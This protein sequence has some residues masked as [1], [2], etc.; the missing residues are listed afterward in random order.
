VR[1]LRTVALAF[2]PSD[3]VMLAVQAG[4]VAAPRADPPGLSWL[5]RLGGRW[6]SLVPLGSIVVVIFAIRGASE[7]ATG[8]TYLALV[9]V[10]ILAALALGWGMRGARPVAALAA[11]ILFAVAWIWRT[12]LSG[13]GA[14]LILS[15]LSC[16]TLGILLSALTPPSWLKVGIVLMAIGDTYLVATDLLQA[17]NNT[18]TLAHPVAGLPQL[19]S[20]LFGNIQMG[21][22]DLFIAAVLGA[23]LANQIH[24]QRQAAAL[25]LLFAAAFDLLFFALSELPATVP[26]A[27]ALIASELW[28]RHTSN[29]KTPTTKTPTEPAER[30]SPARGAPRSE[31][32]PGMGSAPIV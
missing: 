30:P 23:V 32:A 6:W 2:V 8:L 29:T 18:L 3:A 15:A 11:P 9:A 31:A 20:E 19:Q 10:P 1:N 14:A 16:V 22:G 25:T 4:I 17:P 13:E 5:R 26:V 28:H 24:R 7:T 21:Y 12:S 27:S